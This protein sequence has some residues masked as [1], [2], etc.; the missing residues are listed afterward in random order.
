MDCHWSSW[1]STIILLAATNMSK[2]LLDPFP[3]ILMAEN[4]YLTSNHA[5]HPD[6]IG[7]FGDTSEMYK[8]TNINNMN[9]WKRSTP[10]FPHG[11]MI[12]AFVNVDRSIIIY[13]IYLIYL[14]FQILFDTLFLAS[15]SSIWFV[16]SVYLSCLFFVPYLSYLYYYIYIP[17]LSYLSILS[18]L[19][20]VSFV[21][22]S[23][24]LSV[25]VILSALSV[26]LIF[27]YHIYLFYSLCPV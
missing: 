16:M 15:A 20:V 19:S 25:M 23:V 1:P 27:F 11:C 14:C 12:F 3:Y 8:K 22:Y 10:F 7:L 13:H 26:W 2:L 6:A 9:Q 17:Y 21:L 18:I 5:N 4:T 24:L